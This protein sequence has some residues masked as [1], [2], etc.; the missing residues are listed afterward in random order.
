MA[1]ECPYCS[2]TFSTPYAVKRHISD[3]HQHDINKDEDET[4][5]IPK[6]QY[7]EEPDIWDSD[8]DLLLTE[9]QMVRS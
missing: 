4:S 8:D 5:K 1:Y 6:V 9:D 7:K 3:K 2:R